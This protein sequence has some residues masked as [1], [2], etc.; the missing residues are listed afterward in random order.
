MGWDDPV[1]RHLPTF[2]LSDEAADK[3]VSVRDLLCHRS[4]IGPH[5]LLWYR[6][7]WNLDE[8]V[9]R[10]PLLPL[11]A[12]FRGGYQYSS[13]T[14]LAAGKAAENRYGDGWDERVRRRQGRQ[15]GAGRRVRHDRAEPGRVDVLHPA[16]LRPLAALPPERRQGGEGAGGVGQG[17]G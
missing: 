4:G 10:I 8:T 7:P 2:H 6:A 16:R 13:V 14:V 17:T 15:A 11:S 1:R 12:P 3:L 9:R 5:D